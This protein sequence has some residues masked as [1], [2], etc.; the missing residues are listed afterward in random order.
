ML[1]EA[2]IT[3]RSDSPQAARPVR[4]LG[5]DLSANSSGFC[6]HDGTTGVLKPPKTHA[7]GLPRLDW[8]ERQVVGLARL[9]RATVAIVEHV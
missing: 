4:V 5:L 6:L 3:P 2:T 7:D 9:S 1:Q 8:I